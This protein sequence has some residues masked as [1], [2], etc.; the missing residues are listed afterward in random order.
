MIVKNKYCERYLGQQHVHSLGDVS[1][2]YGIVV[3]IAGR[4]FF[5]SEKSVL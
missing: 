2:V 4:F 1:N 3:R 5:P